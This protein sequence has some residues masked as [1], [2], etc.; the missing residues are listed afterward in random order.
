MTVYELLK[1][2]GAGKGEATMWQT[3]K[4]VSDALEVA[5]AATPEAKEKVI[6]DVYAIVV[7]PHYN[8]ELATAQIAK[9]AYV[10]GSGRKVA[11]PHWTK[12]DYHQ[13]YEYYRNKLKVAGVNAWDFAVTLEMQYSDYICT[14]RE[15]WPSAT[16]DE[17]DQKAAELAVA[18]LNDPDDMDDGKIWRRF[19]G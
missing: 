1:E 15:W 8:E 13:A 3:T 18:Y 11:S 5:M 9:M 4:V 19:N 6:K 16:Q 17:L 10:D 7:G 12:S 2:H 14:L